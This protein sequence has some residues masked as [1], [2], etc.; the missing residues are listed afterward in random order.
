MEVVILSSPEQVGAV[1][2][3]VVAALLAR[4]PDA[5]LALPTGRT[6]RP[7]YAELVRLHRAG[8]LSFA[9][10]TS[11][12]LDEYVGLAANHPASFRRYMEQA[13]FEHVDLSPQRIHV[14][15]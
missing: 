14:P 2:A 3:R 5:V 11:F 13:L 12:N 8:Q 10:A 7:L 6:P 15:D 4:K 1:G 9:R